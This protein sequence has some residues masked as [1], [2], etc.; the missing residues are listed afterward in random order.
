MGSRKISP[1][2]EKTRYPHPFQDWYSLALGLGDEGEVPHGV[3][4]PKT[5]CTAL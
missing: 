3:E 1:N 4:H 2:D 5:V